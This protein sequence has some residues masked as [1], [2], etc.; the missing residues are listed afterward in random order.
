MAWGALCV[1]AEAYS[2]PRSR[3]TAIRSGCWRIQ[4]AEVSAFRS[5]K[6]STTRW[7]SRLTRIVPKREPRRNAQ[8]VN[9]KKENRSERAIGEIHDAA[10]DRLASRLDAQT[11]GEPGSSFAA[12]S[13]SNGRDLLAVPDRHPGPWLDK[14]WDA[15][16]EH[17][18]RTERVAAGTFPNCQQQLDTTACTGNIAQRPAIMTVDR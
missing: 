13:Q 17:F 1:A 12:G 5:G 7:L 8:I 2:P 11:G 4:E 10:Q 3:L 9:P 15:L 16:G 18:P 6:R 14:G